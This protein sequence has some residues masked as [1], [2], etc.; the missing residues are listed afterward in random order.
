MRPSITQFQLAEMR[1]RFEGDTKNHH[2]VV[3]H[4]DGAMKCILAKAY[5]TSA[6][7]FRVVTWAKT[8]AISGDMGCFVFSRHSEFDGTKLFRGDAATTGDIQ[9]IAGKVI[10]S[11]N[12]VHEFDLE[13]SVTNLMVDFGDVLGDKADEFKEWFDSVSHGDEG[14]FRDAVENFEVDSEIAISC[15]WPECCVHS[16][17]EHFVWCVL[18][19]IKTIQEYDKT[20][21]VEDV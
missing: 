11:S 6:Y 9:Y 2:Y 8:L 21:K 16:F 20:K 13:R 19:I 17:S 10:A 1:K 15:D 18:A 4:D 12:P 3:E 5:S 7:W 14:G